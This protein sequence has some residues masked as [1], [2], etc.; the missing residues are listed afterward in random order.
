MIMLFSPEFP[1][2]SLFPGLIFCISA[3]FLIIHLASLADV[4]IIA[5]GTTRLSYILG[6]LY[7]A[8]SFTST[9]V[10]YILDYQYE[11]RV[12]SQAT[13]LSGKNQVLV[14]TEQP[15]EQW[16]YLAGLHLKNYGL[17]DDE[18]K[19]QNVAFARFHDLKG[20]KIAK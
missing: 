17:S 3:V 20:V 10:W 8:I 1:N 9:L 5:N 2:R 7:F 18:N 6:I 13:W 11:E 16:N 19:W 4:H 15:P 12:L 14:I